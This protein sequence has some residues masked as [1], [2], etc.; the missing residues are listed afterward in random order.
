M[1]LAFSIDHMFDLL[2]K[3]HKA[4]ARCR[5]KILCLNRIYPRS[6]RPGISSSFGLSSSHRL[7]LPILGATPH[8]VRHGESGSRRIISAYSCCDWGRSIIIVLLVSA[9]E[10][11]NVRKKPYTYHLLTFFEKRN[12]KYRI[13]LKIFKIIIKQLPKMLEHLLL[14][15]AG[16]LS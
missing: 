15:S 14:Q 5:M 13:F 6:P 12:Q 1:Q 7:H 3:R 11:F 2:C 9:Y 4:D 8:C 16:V 10:V